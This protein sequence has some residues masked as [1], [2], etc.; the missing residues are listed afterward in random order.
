VSRVIARTGMPTVTAVPM[1]ARGFHIERGRAAENDD[2]R[3]ERNEQ[4]SNHRFLPKR[5][6]KP[7]PSRI[8][9][10]SPRRPTEAETGRPH[11]GAGTTAT[12]KRLQGQTGYE[13]GRPCTRPGRPNG[14][15][16]VEP[17]AH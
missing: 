15:P 1:R 12:L 11:R 14:E 6:D 5:Y 16:L 7:L 2:G 17:G 8:E 3:D 10:P 4:T 9:P 13:A